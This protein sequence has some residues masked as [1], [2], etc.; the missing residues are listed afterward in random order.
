MNG[1]NV[2]GWKTVNKATEERIM[3]PSR[4]KNVVSFFCSELP[5]PMAISGIL[6]Y[7]KQSA[8]HGQTIFQQT[9]TP[10]THL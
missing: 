1:K 5:Q 6:R 2:A 3:A 4:I 10:G 8:R 9:E 7:E